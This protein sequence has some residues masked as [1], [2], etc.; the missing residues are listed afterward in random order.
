[1]NVLDYSFEKKSFN[2]SLM[3]FYVCYFNRKSTRESI[4]IKLW[5][6]VCELSKIS[7]AISRIKV[8]NAKNKNKGGGSEV[9]DAVFSLKQ[10]ER[11]GGRAATESRS[12]F[13]RV[14]GRARASGVAGAIIQASSA[15]TYHFPRLLLLL[16]L[17][18]LV[19]ALFR[20]RGKLVLVGASRV[21]LRWPPPSHWCGL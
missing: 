4:I 19:R 18:R 7:A 9:Q 6:S 13:T 21:C 16:L 5:M 3:N 2:F 10:G 14:G 1:M 8:T 11:A 20:R 12:I 15:E 17:T